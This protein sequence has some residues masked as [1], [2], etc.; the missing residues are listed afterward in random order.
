MTFSPA[1]TQ[2]R[3]EFQCFKPLS[4]VP[5]ET[6]R[7]PSWM[8]S[9]PGLGDELGLWTALLLVLSSQTTLHRHFVMSKSK[10]SS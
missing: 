10:R 5:V 6:R 8:T 9:C 2:K 3:F 1:S 7:L 4:A